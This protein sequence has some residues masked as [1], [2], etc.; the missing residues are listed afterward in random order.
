MC[1]SLPGSQFKLGIWANPTERIAR[2]Y[3][4]TIHP[5]EQDRQHIAKMTL[6]DYLPHDNTWNPD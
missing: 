5:D 4:G 6:R 3:S 2:K 1:K